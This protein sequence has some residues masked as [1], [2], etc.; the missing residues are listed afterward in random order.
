MGFLAERFPDRI[1]RGLVGGPNFNTTVAYLPS[2]REKR[3]NAGRSRALHSYDVSHGVKTAEDHARADAFFRKARGRLHAFRVKDWMDYTLARADSR[4]VQLTSTTFRISKVYGQDEPTFE[5]VRPLTRLVS[6]TVSVWKDAVLLTQGGGAGQYTVN[7]DTGVV[8]FGTGPGASVL[9]ATC[10]FDVPCR[11]DFDAK[12][13]ELVGRRP[14]GTQ[15]I[16]WEGISIV[17]DP[18][19]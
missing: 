2:G 5:E 17:E 16:R 4:L 18:A 19:G 15:F 13:A 1:S 14:D 3:N 6:G 12:S 10:E 9:E 11:F 7:A 8:T